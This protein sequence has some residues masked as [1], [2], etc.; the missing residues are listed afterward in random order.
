[1]TKNITVAGQQTRDFAVKKYTVGLDLGDGW[2]WYCV[3]DEGGEVVFEGKLS[4][5]S[6]AL[7]EVFGAMPESRVALETGMHSP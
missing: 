4:T 6:K 3:L 1:M 5:T 2:S 7:G